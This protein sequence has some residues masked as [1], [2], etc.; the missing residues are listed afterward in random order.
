MWISF[1]TLKSIAIKLMPKF[2]NSNIMIVNYKRKIIYKKI[3]NTIFDLNGLEKYYEFPDEIPKFKKYIEL[4]KDKK[5]PL[6]YVTIQ[7]RS[8]KNKNLYKK[9]L[10]VLKC[11]LFH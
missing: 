11:R 8:I 6:V 4:F 3:K 2:I 1:F 5:D 7:E 9:L 10:D